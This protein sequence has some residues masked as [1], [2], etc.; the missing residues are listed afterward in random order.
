M[1]YGMWM[2][3]C[4]HSPVLT[5]MD[6]LTTWYCIEMKIPAN[7]YHYNNIALKCVQSGFQ[8]PITY[9]LLLHVSILP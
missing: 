9:F 6:S 3:S 7:T 2:Q 1:V 8:F 5:N 4:M